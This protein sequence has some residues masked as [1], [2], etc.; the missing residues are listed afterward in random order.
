MSFGGVAED[1]C[2]LRDERCDQQGTTYQSPKMDGRALL[3]RGIR[4][5]DGTSVSTPSFSSLRVPPLKPL[6]ELRNKFGTPV[7]FE[8]PLFCG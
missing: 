5:I 2:D 6:L 3:W 8:F 1:D 4:Y 7:G